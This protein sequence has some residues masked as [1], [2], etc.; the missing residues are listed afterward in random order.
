MN[1]RNTESSV[2]EL[3][4]LSIASPQGFMAALGLLRVCSADLGMPVRLSWS[5]SH[6]RLHGADWPTLLDGLRQHMQGR[7]AAPEFNF[8]VTRE[9]GE[10]AVVGKLHGILPQDYRA[11]V[12]SLRD[13]PR[14]LGFLA[15]FA[16]DCVLT[17]KG[18]V[19]RNQLDFTTGQQQFMVKVRE[20]A[21]ELRPQHPRFEERL[22]HALF[23]GPYEAGHSFS[24]DPVAVRNHACE[25]EAPTH[26]GSP[27]SQPFAVWLAIEALPLHPV[28]P[29]APGRA[30]TTGLQRD[31]YVWPQWQTALDL[32]A[33]TLLRQRPLD[34]LAQLPGV[35]AIWQSAI[36]SSGRYSILS[37]AVRTPGY[38]PD[39]GRFATAADARPAGGRP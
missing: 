13:N 18:H 5:A 35:D 34:S 25:A 2:L 15:A 37:T 33:V 9:D 1:T 11:A 39:P 24:W 26:S 16:T 23:G 21:H 8:P 17:A 3:T 38:R 32:T 7:A 29:T 6:A 19:A 30:S 12:H 4:G 20:L 27:P 36:S 14:A 22:H 10:T 28:I 31:T